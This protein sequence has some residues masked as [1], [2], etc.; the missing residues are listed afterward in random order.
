MV[1]TTNQILY[2][3]PPFSIAM[4]FLPSTLGNFPPSLTSPAWL[5]RGPCRASA[6]HPRRRSPASF[7]LGY[8]RCTIWLFNIAMENGSFIDDFPI[9][10]SIYSGFSMAMSNNQR[11][12]VFFYTMHTCVQGGAPPSYKWVIIPLTIDRSRINHS[13]WTYKP[14]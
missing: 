7:F 8:Y 3:Y 9:N 6:S 4:W 5:G 2:I 13:Y 11:V 12:Y 14:T 1:E 10:T